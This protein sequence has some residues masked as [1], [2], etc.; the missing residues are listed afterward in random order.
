M[1]KVIRHPTDMRFV[2]SPAGAAGNPI[3]FEREVLERYQN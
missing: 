1:L 3:D 2:P